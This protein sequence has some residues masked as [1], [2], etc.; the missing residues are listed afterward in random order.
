MRSDPWRSSDVMSSCSTAGAFMSNE[1]DTTRGVC[2]F[3][4][5]STDATCPARP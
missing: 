2:M 5:V 4:Y 3:P 1:N